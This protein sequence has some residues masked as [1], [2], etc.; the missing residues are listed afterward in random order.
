MR[1]FIT[2]RHWSVNIRK[3]LPAYRDLARLVDAGSVTADGAGLLRDAIVG[4][5]SIIVSGATHAGN[6]ACHL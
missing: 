1:G 6:T 5:R 4:G 3:F 2:R